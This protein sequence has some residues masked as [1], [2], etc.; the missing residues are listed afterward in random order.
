MIRRSLCS[1]PQTILTSV[2][3]S[4]PGLLEEILQILGGEEH[5]NC[6]QS[7][8]EKKYDEEEHE[9]DDEV[10]DTDFAQVSMA[11]TDFDS[12]DFKKVYRK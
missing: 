4:G 12:N 6:E 8:L 11:H 2:E 3:L 7:A 5:Q 10:S 9:A 1:F